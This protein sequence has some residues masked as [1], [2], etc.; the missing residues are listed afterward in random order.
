M[1]VLTEQEL[2]VGVRAPASR[3]PLYAAALA[4]GALVCA[5]VAHHEA[6]ADEA[7]AWLL[8]RDASLVDLWTRLL[9]YEGTTGLWQTLLHLFV[10]LGLPYGAMNVLSGVLGLAAACVLL[11]RAPFPLALRVALPFTFYLCYQYAVIARSYDLLPLLLFTCA[12]TGDRASTPSRSWLSRVLVTEPRPSGSGCPA[13]SNDV[14]FSAQSSPR[15]GLLRPS[16]RPLLFTLLLCLMAAVSIHGMVLALAAGVSALINCPDRKRFAVHVM[17]FAAIVILL[18]ASAWPARD[19]TFI[20]GLNFSFGHLLEVCAKSF[21]AA[22]TGEWVSSLAVVALSVPLLWRGGGWLFFV[23]AASLL[24]GIASVVYSQVWHHGILF[25]AWLFAVWISAGRRTTKGDRLSYKLALASLAIVSAVQC[26]WTVCS[27]AYDWNHPYSGSRAAARGLHE[28]DLEGK[29]LYAIGYACIAIEP[30][31]PHNIFANVNDGRPEAYWDWS[32]RN[33]VNEDSRRLREAPPGYV[34]V[35]YKN[36]FER[37]VWSS[38]V[39]QSGYRI[40][41]HFDG[42]TFWQTRVLEP[43]SYDLFERSAM[44]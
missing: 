20:A 9:H 42:N 32:R 30:Y 23:L 27:I 33:H 25:L 39:R 26:Y 35:G 37:G 34:V 36:Q 14:V 44:P 1:D 31:F 7:Q 13:N 16:E 15:D 18:A 10:Q 24:C 41:R 4:Y 29:K 17:C 12:A 6:W 11:W 3:L 43:E 8:A 19:G 28:L 5:A 40:I 2:R 21:G 22:F 38:L